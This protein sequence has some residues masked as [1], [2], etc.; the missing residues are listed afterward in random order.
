MGVIRKD[1]LAQTQKRHSWEGPGAPTKARQTHRH[2]HRYG[3]EGAIHTVKYDV[4]FTRHQCN[5]TTGRDR[6]I[7]QKHAIKS[8]KLTQLM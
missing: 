5:I 7:Q 2:W 1:Q 4:K 6:D 3:K 8:Y